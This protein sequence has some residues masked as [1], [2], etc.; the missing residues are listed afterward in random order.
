M[1]HKQ[2]TPGKVDKSTRRWVVAEHEAAH[3]VVARALGHR[4]DHCWINDEHGETK[5]SL[6]WSRDPERAL[7]EMAVIALAGP[8]ASSRGRWFLPAGCAADK[9]IAAQFLNEIG[10]RPAD[11]RSRA[12]RLVG[13]QWGHIQR[14]AFHLYRNGSL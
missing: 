13:S 2:S 8:D 10:A 12:H 3:A 6:P 14:T 5:A 9:R 7:F 11:A 4:V 1:P